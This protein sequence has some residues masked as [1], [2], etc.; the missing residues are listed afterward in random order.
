MNLPLLPFRPVKYIEDI[1]CTVIVGSKGKIVSICYNIKGGL[2]NIY[3]PK[4]MN[5]EHGDNELW[6]ST[7]FECFIGSSCTPEYYEYNQSPDGDSAC[8]KFSDYRNRQSAFDRP[9]DYAFSLTADEYECHARIDIPSPYTLPFYLGLA[10][11]IKDRRNELHYFGL[12]HPNDAPDFHLR[13][14]QKL[15]F[16]DVI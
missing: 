12:S 6:R 15:I 5:P 1:F 16:K 3:W 8:Y 14:H 13:S 10:V 7:C 9:S 2:E 4:K 11:I